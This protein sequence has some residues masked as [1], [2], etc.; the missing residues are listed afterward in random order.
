MK[1]KILARLQ[2]E[3]FKNINIPMQYKII[4]KQ[5]FLKQNNF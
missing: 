2:S 4:P 3:T 5:K 1:L